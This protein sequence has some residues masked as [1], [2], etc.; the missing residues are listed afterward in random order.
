MITSCWTFWKGPIFII[1]VDHLKEDQN[2]QE[3]KL[4]IMDE[5]LDLLKKSSETTEAPT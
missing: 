1:I 2:E 4:Q 5:I 3:L